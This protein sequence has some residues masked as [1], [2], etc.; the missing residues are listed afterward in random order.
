MLHQNVRRGKR[1]LGQNSLSARQLAC[2]MRMIAGAGSH[3]LFRAI[4]ALY[5]TLDIRHGQ[6]KLKKPLT[7]RPFAAR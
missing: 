2:E 1:R 4:E 6:R 3:E 7:Q 5:L